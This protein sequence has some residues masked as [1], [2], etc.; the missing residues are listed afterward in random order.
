MFEPLETRA[1]LNAT[2][3]GAGV[4]TVNGSRG[5][6]I[7]I[8]SQLGPNLVVSI[9]PE[10]FKQPFAAASVTSIVVNCDDGNDL[11]NID[12][13]I[14]KMASVL[15]GEGN[16][17]LTGGGGN[18]LLNGQ[19]GDDLLDGGL[20]GDGMIGETGNDTVDY[21]ARTADLVISLQHLAP[22]ANDG[23]AG[24]HDDIDITIDTVL[25]GS[26]N[27]DISSELTD[28]VRVFYGHAGNDTLRGSAGP[29]HLHGGP[30]DDSLLGSAGDDTMIGAAGKDVFRGGEGIDT[31]S[32]YYATTRV[33]VD[34]DGNS[35]DGT[36]NEQDN[37]HTDCENLIGGRGNDRLVGNT[38]SSAANRIEGGPGNDSIEG[39]NGHDLLIGGTGND[40]LNGGNG[41]DTLR[42]GPGID[43]LIGGGSL[44]DVAFVTGVIGPDDLVEEDVEIV[45]VE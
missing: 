20:G 5:N 1:L 8:L 3:D 6:D 4:L 43:R 37:V 17:T 38:Q 45:Q 24:E 22:L 14:T 15:G 23:E 28:N 9:Q 21:R 11:L 36:P 18:D 26:G 35:D 12:Q 25:G 32:Y 40:T 44:A 33:I 7:I 42:G 19:G 10:N 41:N 13:S 39:R 31:V 27:D 2:L 30:G 16:D 34:I 29:D